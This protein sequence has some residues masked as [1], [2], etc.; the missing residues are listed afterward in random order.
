MLPILQSPEVEGRII[1][2]NVCALEPVSLVVK[3]IFEIVFP[4]MLLAVVLPTNNLMP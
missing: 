4:W 2:E 1:P 3:E